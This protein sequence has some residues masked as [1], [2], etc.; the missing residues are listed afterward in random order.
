MQCSP[1]EIA[2]LGGQA[3]SKPLDSARVYDIEENK[4][5]P[6]RLAGAVGIINHM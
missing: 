2:I 1:T 5:K 4:F 6:S 3:G